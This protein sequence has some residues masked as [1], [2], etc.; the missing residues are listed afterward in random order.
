MKLLMLPAGSRYHTAVY[1][2]AML[3]LP[4]FASIR[5][6]CLTNEK[7][8]NCKT[9]LAA[10]RYD[11]YC[12]YNARRVALSSSALC[13]LHPSVSIRPDQNFCYRLCGRLLL[14]RI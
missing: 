5:D 8:L 1:Y 2:H 6:S 10:A 4:T 13:M 12:T 7:P 14:V 9:V 3:G 11:R